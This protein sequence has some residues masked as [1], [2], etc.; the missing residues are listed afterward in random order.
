MSKPVLTLLRNTP[1]TVFT[2]SHQPEKEPLEI[3]SY[4]NTTVWFR[5]TKFYENLEGR[6]CKQQRI[7]E[8]EDIHVWRTC[9]FSKKNGSQTRQKTFWTLTSLFLILPGSFQDWMPMHLCQIILW[10]VCCSSCLKREFEIESYGF[11][12]RILS[13]W[14]SFNKILQLNPGQRSWIKLR[15]PS[16]TII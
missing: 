8:G 3:V 12:K 7:W 2:P 14:T 6:G 5:R 13:T 11:D 1:L 15:N 4:A 9:L 10:M 16:T